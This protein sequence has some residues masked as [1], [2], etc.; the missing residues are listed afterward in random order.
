M[1]LRSKFKKKKKRKKVKL[2][3]SRTYY[4]VLQQQLELD[5]M[6]RYH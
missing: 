4:R 6:V 1:F 5:Y 3:S 2:I